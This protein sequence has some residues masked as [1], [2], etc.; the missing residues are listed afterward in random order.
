MSL[1]AELLG[2]LVL[3]RSG[4]IDNV[5]IVALVAAAPIIPVIGFYCSQARR[6][7]QAGFT[8]ADLRAALDVAR[9]EREEE[10]VF[11]VVEH[12]LTVAQRSLR[13]GAYLSA[14]L[15]VGI[16]V[17]TVGVPNWRI[18]MVISSWVLTF[19]L[20]LSC[21][22]NEVPLLPGVVRRYFRVGLRE[23]LWRSR[24]GA[25]LAARLGAPAT[26]RPVG[27]GLFRSTEAALGLAAADL[28]AMLPGDHRER[29]HA[30]PELVRMLEGRATEAR[31]RLD[32][33]E[34]LAARAGSDEATLD[35]RRAA[36]KS[37]LSDSVAALEGIRL[38]L[39]RLHAGAADLAPLTTL[40]DAA[41]HL[42]E[43]VARLADGRRALAEG[44]GRRIATP[45]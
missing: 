43:D 9:L 18:G 38:D 24:L 45:V 28:Y 15:S 14:A 16:S 27:A 26:S 40:L 1:T 35:G 13:R 7:F 2:I 21:N 6:L 29:L 42:G 12:Q 10:S 32:Q 37:M 8:L 23:R 30:L 36:A 25:A 17:V 31:A 39:L 20:L 22:A 41:R 4:R 5:A 19:V 33:L 3:G 11:S 34:A 44:G